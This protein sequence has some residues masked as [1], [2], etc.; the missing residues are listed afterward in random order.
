MS[1]FLKY[2]PSIS[3]VDGRQ[4]FWWLGT[5]DI[6]GF[7]RFDFLSC[8]VIWSFHPGCLTIAQLLLSKPTVVNFTSPV[9]FFFVHKNTPQ[10]AGSRSIPGPPLSSVLME[11]LLTSDLFIVWSFKKLSWRVGAT[12]LHRFLLYGYSSNLSMSISVV[13]TPFLLLQCLR[14]FSREFC[15]SVNFIILLYKYHIIFSTFIILHVICHLLKHACVFLNTVL[16]LFLIPSFI[17]VM[18]I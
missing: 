8:L 15:D 1:L 16:S 17:I 3:V 11:S 2:G 10:K 5:E 12:I 14:V 4:W 13:Q 7:C 18:L 9:F 6:P